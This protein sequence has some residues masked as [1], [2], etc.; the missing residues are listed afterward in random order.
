M[1]WFLETSP[2]ILWSTICFIFKDGHSTL[3]LCSS[4]W[5]RTLCDLG[6]VI[7]ISKRWPAD[8]CLRLICTK[9]LNPAHSA[10]MAAKQIL[11]ETPW[12]TVMMKQLNVLVDK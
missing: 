7:D 1:L 11:L 4:T 3:I 8:I 10:T 6:D 12:K 9:I 2:T 5:L